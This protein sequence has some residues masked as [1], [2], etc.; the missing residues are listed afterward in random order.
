MFVSN[1]YLSMKYILFIA[2]MLAMTAVSMAQGKFKMS[3]KIDGVGKDKLVIGYRGFSGD[4]EKVEKKVSVKN[5]E[6]TFSAKP[7]EVS[8]GWMHLESNPRQ[9]LYFLV[10]PGE[11]AIFSGGLQKIS[12]HWD[13]SL[14]YQ[15]LQRVTDIKQPFSKEYDAAKQEKRANIAAGMDEEKADSILVSRNYEILNR[16]LPVHLKYIAEHN[17]E[18]ATADIV[19]GVSHFVDVDSVYSQLAPR[20]RNGRMKAFLDKHEKIARQ[21]VAYRK[22]KNKVQNDTVSVGD[23]AQELNLKDMQGNVL[24]LDSLRGKYVLLDFWGSWCTWC[25]KGFP[26]MKEYYAKYKDKLEIIGIDCNDSHEKWVA[27]VE[28]HGAPWLHVRAEDD[29][30]TIRYKVTGYPFKILISPEGRV[31]N[32]YRG[33]AEE[34]YQY[35]DEVLGK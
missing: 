10:V 11:E 33:E 13:G 3:G 17:D 7:T 5:G 15:Q 9:E 22:A 20:V 21:A 26:K 4:A 6:F 32:S 19:V 27:A 31:L 23:M 16:L 35:I 8:Q 1:N 14:F 24:R 25:I 29:E 2:M 28:K 12:E 34:F 30:V 18:E